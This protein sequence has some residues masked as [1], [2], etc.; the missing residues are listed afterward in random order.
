MSVK[1]LNSYI[2]VEKSKKSKQGEGLLHI[3]EVADSVGVIK[4]LGEDYKGELQIGDKVYFGDKRNE[5]RMG[6]MDIQVMLPD[7]IFAVVKES[8]NGE[9]KQS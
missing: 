2:G 3:P 5:V 8:Q 1:M 4:F 9:E 7:N 6:K